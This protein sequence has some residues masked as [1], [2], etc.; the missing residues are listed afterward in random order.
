[1][2]RSEMLKTLQGFLIGLDATI[3]PMSYPD[4]AR[5]ILKFLEHQGMQPPLYYDE[6]FD[7]QPECDG[8]IPEWEPEDKNNKYVKF[9]IFYLIDKY[10][11]TLDQLKERALGAAKRRQELEDRYTVKD[12]E[13]ELIETRNGERHFMVSVFGE[14]E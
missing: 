9:S 12:V 5:S 2:K 14:K 4:K 7:D 8:M 6:L 11:L 10:N 3:I 13:L 1:M